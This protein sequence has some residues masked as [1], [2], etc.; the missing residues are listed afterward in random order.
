MLK[1]FKLVVVNIIAFVLILAVLEGA[2]SLIFTAV[3]IHRATGVREQFHS[4]HDPTIGW[5]SL[6]NVRLP[7][8]YGPGISLH[9][10]AQAFRGDHDIRAGRARRKDPGHL[11]GR[12]VHARLRGE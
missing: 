11:L 10:N 6:P 2:A 7:D 12:L 5:V 1:V 8:L 9:T 4:T 3:R